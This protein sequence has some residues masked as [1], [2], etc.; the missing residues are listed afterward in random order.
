MNNN[1]HLPEDMNQNQNL[2][3]DELI[4]LVVNDKKQKIENDGIKNIIKDIDSNKKSISKYNKLNQK[5]NLYNDNKKFKTK[6][7]CINI[8][9]NDINKNKLV[10]E[11][12][13]EFHYVNYSIYEK[14]KNEN[15]I[16]IETIKNIEV[17][18]QKE[19]DFL[20][21]ER[22]R[23]KNK[24]KILNI[25]N[26]KLKLNSHINQTEIE[27]KNN[28]TKDLDK[29]LE[30]KE[31][32]I[33]DYKNKIIQYKND[34]N[35][36]VEDFDKKKKKFEK[37]IP[38]LTL[39]IKKIEYDY[40][41][42][43]IA[44]EKEKN[45]NIINNILLKDKVNELRHFSELFKLIDAY[46]KNIMKDNSSMIEFNIENKINNNKEQDQNDNY[47][48]VGII[49]N[50]L[51]C[52]MNS[53]IQILKNIRQFGINIL[54]YDKEDIITNSLRNLLN[55]L[56][57][58]NEK[59]V[60]INEFKNDFGSTY[61][62]FREDRQ[63]DSTIFLIY[64]LQHLNKV[65]KRP[66]QPIT[67]IYLF[68]NLNLS[69]SEE[70]E[71]ENFLDKYESVNNS[72]ITDLFFGYQMDKII[73]VKCE[74]NHNSFQSFNVL[75]LPLICENEEVKSLEDSL[76]SYLITK[77]KHNLEGFECPHCGFRNTSHL[78]CIIKLPQILIINLKRVGENTVY[79][80]E[81]KIP[82]TMK[83]KLIDKLNSFNRTYELIGFIKHF[84]NE[85]M[86]HNIAF[87]KNI[88]DNKWYSYNDT[89]VKEEKEFPS[90]DKSF[91]LFYQ[92]VE[93]N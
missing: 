14:L 54:T 52:Y 70:N 30:N 5:E 10:I 18:Y 41:E 74:K 92:I 59:F 29:I 26:E 67:S 60:S 61:I 72:F 81:I 24:I 82:K 78:T 80:N 19:I 3:N 16:L 6:D 69:L 25:N 66:K 15:K 55:N 88:F 56:Y 35:F 68:K 17:K 87:T 71:L 49:N 13:F 79:Y 46:K 33:I 50:G 28:G 83:T 43:K 44:F 93:N 23:L 90:T 34:I 45:K 63:N 20:K 22:I 77:D 85:N 2:N 64:L 58:S 47:G 39:K 37:E 38:E 1:Q 4:S 86:G 89:I 91:L 27:T 73:C 57:Y 40:K 42:L 84:G 8:I 7:D 11:N 51:T 65:F 36:I 48:K 53:I 32:E 75:N 12:I 62:K 21:D 31:K 76:N 9:I